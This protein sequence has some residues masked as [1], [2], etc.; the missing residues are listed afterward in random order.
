MTNLSRYISAELVKAYQQAQYVIHEES[1]DI[2]LRVGQASTALATLMRKHDTQSAALL[3][4]FNPYSVL[5]SAKENIRNHNALI[6]DIQALEL[7]WVAAEGADASNRWPSEPSVLVLGIC[8]QN[9]EHLADQ[10]QQ[11]AFLWIASTDSLVSLNLRYPK[12]P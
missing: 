2:Q 7:K 3:T 4:A 10:Y 11:N 5:A 6:A 8:L 9:A 1:G 12:L